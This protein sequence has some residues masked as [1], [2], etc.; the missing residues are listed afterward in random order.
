MSDHIKGQ[1]RY[2]VTLFPEALDDFV[3]AENPVR[4]IDVFVDKLNLASLGFENVVPKNTVR[5]EYHPAAM[6]KLFIYGYLNRVQ[7]SRLL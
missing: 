1:S 2:Q 7:S 6:L 3:N 4:V 5:P